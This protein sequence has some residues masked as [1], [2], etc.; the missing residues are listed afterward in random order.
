MTEQPDAPPSGSAGRAAGW[1][2]L[3]DQLHW[4]DT[5][6]SSCQRSFKRAKL[7]QLVLSGAVPVLALVEVPAVVTA[8]VAAAVVVLEGLQQLNQWQANWI[9]YRATAESLKHER[10]LYLAHAGPYR[11]WDSERVLSQE[12][13]KWAESRE[14]HSAD[15]TAH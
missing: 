8:S 12:H 6:S 9:L 2:R 13:A 11:S 7:V 5:K 1:E 14:D 4:Y 10:Y 3:E 15:A